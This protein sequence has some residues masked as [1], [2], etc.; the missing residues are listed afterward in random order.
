MT[1]VPSY[2]I[3]E[4]PPTIPLTRASD[5]ESQP[6]AA[7]ELARA[8]DGLPLALH[9]RRTIDVRR[10]V[11]RALAVPPGEEAPRDLARVLD[12]LD[13][14]ARAHSVGRRI[15]RSGK[16]VYYETAG[17]IE[18]HLGTTLLAR[19]LG[20]VSPM[21]LPEDVARA[22][23]PSRFESSAVLSVRDLAGDAAPQGAPPAV[24]SGRHARM[25]VGL[26]RDTPNLAA[27][28]G[29]ARE[30][31]TRPLVFENLLAVRSARW[32]IQDR[33]RQRTT[34]GRLADLGAY[35]Q[36]LASAGALAWSVSRHDATRLVAELARAVD[37]DWHERRR[38]HG[39]L[40]PGNVLLDD[41]AIRAFDAL[42]VPEGETSPGMTEGWAAPEQVLARPLG[43]ATDV[44]ALALMAAA[45][46]SG[47]VY[48][49]EQA[50]VVPAL[51]D[52]RRRL[53][54]MKDPEIWLDPRAIELPT[55][56]RNAWRSMLMECLA[57][58]PARRPPRGRELANRLDALLDRWELP[59]RRSV[60]CGPGRLE[61]LV[62]SREPVW[63]L[64]DHA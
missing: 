7:F 2:W 16:R 44:F 29:G 36:A 60:A 14:V 56:A 34:D 47:V 31:T 20:A 22:A 53:R 24:T 5:L 25:W 27:T 41:A 52:G 64:D 1:I 33:D 23:S 51:G 42:D 19:M 21:V 39:D 55:E 63:I 15:V 8:P 54:M 17:T 38:V 11:L 45:A 30:P 62:G 10:P 58:D 32:H 12:E 57:F 28:P 43:P 3:R 26:S 6:D 48:G 46:V 4:A 50:V 61:Y 37:R 13:R 59:G 40:K 18:G 35:R 49:E 9:V